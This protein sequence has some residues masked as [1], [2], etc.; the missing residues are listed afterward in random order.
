LVFT[1]YYALSDMIEGWVSAGCRIV[2]AE[3]MID[4]L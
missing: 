2:G 3:K 4:Q 1:S